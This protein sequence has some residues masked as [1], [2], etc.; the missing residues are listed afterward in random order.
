MTDSVELGDLG[1]LFAQ[2]S[3]EPDFKAP[4][5]AAHD[6]T[7]RLLL[8]TAHATGGGTRG[9]RAARLSDPGAL[10]VVGDRHGALTLG[11]IS[12]FG[13]RGV[14]V[15]QDPVLGERALNANAARLGFTEAYEQ[16]PLDVSLLRD[17]GFVLLQLPRS[18]AELDE[19]AQA[20]AR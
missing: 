4:R 18:L 8:E 7:D 3:R 15:Y 11:A 20:I 16:H 13:A 1:E 2:L 5:L 6:A 12:V 10:V 17:A 9:G 19:L 14:R